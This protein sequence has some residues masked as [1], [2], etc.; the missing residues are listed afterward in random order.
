[1]NLILDSYAILTYLQG[2]EGAARVKEIFQAAQSG[3]IAVYLPLIN[4]GEILYIVERKRGLE[5]AHRTLSALRQLPLTI[6]PANEDNVLAA[7]H[8]KAQFPISYADAF[9]IA[10]AHRLDAKILT[11]DPE[12][13][14]VRY[15]VE[16][17]KLL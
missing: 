4:L 16:I 17:E 9:V 11:G 6:L 7:A 3:E 12:F 1:M 5:E 14:A 13:D 10:A 2:E 15:L 8:I